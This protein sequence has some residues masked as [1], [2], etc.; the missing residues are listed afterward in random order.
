MKFAACNYG[1]F[2]PSLGI[3]W[4]WKKCGDLNEVILVL[5]KVDIDKSAFKSY[6]TSSLTSSLISCLAFEAFLDKPNIGKH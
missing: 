3:V 6:L 5:D 1:E 4:E 2:L